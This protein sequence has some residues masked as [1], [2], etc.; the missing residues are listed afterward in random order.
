MTEE[1]LL[2]AGLSVGAYVSPHVRGWSER[3]RVDGAEADFEAAVCAIRPQAE[4]LGATQ[5][6]A[7]TAAALVA[8]AEAEVDAAVV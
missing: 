8:F 3:I 5:F 6:E 2:D 1:L 4:A 7:L